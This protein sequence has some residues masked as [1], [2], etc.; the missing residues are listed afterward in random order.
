[1]A[2]AS[3]SVS[4]HLPRQARGKNRAVSLQMRQQAFDLL[5]YARVSKSDVARPRSSVQ[6]RFLTVPI[7]SALLDVSGRPRLPGCA[8]RTGDLSLGG[9]FPVPIVDRL[10]LMLTSTATIS[11]PSETMRCGRDQPNFCAKS[12]RMG[13]TVLSPE[14][15]QWS[16]ESGTSRPV[17][18]STSTLRPPQH[19]R[20]GGWRGS[21]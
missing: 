2:R 5:R 11:G 17:T 9:K 15:P 16:C 6:H 19:S 4:D 18:Q 21:G 1:M 8:R 12:F 10:E 7:R 3:G 14:L 13:R 20:D